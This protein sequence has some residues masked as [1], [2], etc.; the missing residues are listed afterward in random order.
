MPEENTK[1]CHNPIY[2]EGK[3]EGII[4]TLID[5]SFTNEFILDYICKVFNLSIHE[6]EE[7]LAK[8]KDSFK[9]EKT[10]IE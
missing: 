1:I 6:A 3:K 2:I 10:F 5:L 7:E 8:Y 9:I 4:C